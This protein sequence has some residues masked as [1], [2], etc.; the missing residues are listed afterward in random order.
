M[1][2]ECCARR[3]QFCSQFA[4]SAVFLVWH[5]GLWQVLWMRKAISR[6]PE[7]MQLF[8]GY[9]IWAWQIAMA[10]A[11]LHTHTHTQHSCHTPLTSSSSRCILRCHGVPS[12]LITVRPHSQNSAS[13]SQT[14]CQGHSW[15]KQGCSVACLRWR[16]SSKCEIW[17][18]VFNIY[19]NPNAYKQLIEI[20]IQYNKARCY[21]KIKENTWQGFVLWGKK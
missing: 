14:I 13:A 9:D 2:S 20:G 18:K 3:Q 6:C 8:L 16:R 21:W 15:V 4:L 5:G 12:N 19:K 11:V 17:T 7:P 1:F 10:P